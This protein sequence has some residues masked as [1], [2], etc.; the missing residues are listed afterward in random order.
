[1]PDTNSKNS[2]DLL[3]TTNAIF[4][5]LELGAIVLESLLANK[6]VLLLE[7]G[8]MVD[9]TLANRLEKTITDAHI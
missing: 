9:A 4:A 3:M 5:R 2:D 1:M 8:K 7:T 6:E